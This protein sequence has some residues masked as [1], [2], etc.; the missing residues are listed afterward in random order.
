M[1]K[2]GDALKKTYKTGS[3]LLAFHWSVFM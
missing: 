3:V 1:S 2:L